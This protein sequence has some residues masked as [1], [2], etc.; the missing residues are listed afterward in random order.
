MSTWFVPLEGMHDKNNH[1]SDS[2]IICYFPPQGVS[3]VKKAGKFVNGIAVYSQETAIEATSKI[4][5]DLNNFVRGHLPG[6]HYYDSCIDIE[7]LF[8]VEAALAP[9]YELMKHENYPM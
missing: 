1:K 9:L 5:E 4:I 8:E 7:R 3:F 6:R 2:P